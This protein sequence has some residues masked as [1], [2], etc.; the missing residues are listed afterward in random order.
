MVPKVY[1][2]KHCGQ[3]ES[4]VRH[5]FTRRGSQR[6]R[7]KSCRRAWAPAGH[8]HTLSTEKEALI[9]KALQERLSQRAIAAPSLVL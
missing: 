9:T 2:C 7:C 5:G 1:R 4:V 3:W 6:L 8:S